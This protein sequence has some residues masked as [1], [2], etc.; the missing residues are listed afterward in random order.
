MSAGDWKDL[1]FACQN[2][3]LELVKFH[4]TNDVNPNFQ[5]AEFM[6]SPLLEAIRYNQLEIVEY[7]LANG[8]DPHQKEWMGTDDA[9]SV[10][11][12]LKNKQMIEILKNFR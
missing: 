11:K 9:F 10:A 6:T 2:G 5:H 7:L 12:S 8:A 1:F 4:I 3:D